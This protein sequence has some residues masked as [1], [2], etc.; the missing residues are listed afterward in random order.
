MTQHREPEVNVGEVMHQIKADIA[1]QNG[2]AFRQSGK[3]SPFDWSRLMMNMTVA[4]QHA[5][6]GSRVL[7]MIRF[8]PAIRWLVRL[9]GRVV[10]YLAQVVTIPQ[11]MYNQAVL[12]VLRD[13][14]DGVR[15]LD[16]SISHLQTSLTLQER[17]F[18]M[19][20][21]E[22]EQKLPRSTRPGANTGENPLDEAKAH[23]LD[24]FY[25]SFEDRFRG[26]RDEIKQH[27]QFYLPFFKAAPPGQDRA[28]ILDL[29]CGRGE[30]LELL[31]D[32]NLNAK[33]IDLN[34]IMVDQ[35]REQG[36]AV[37]EADALAYLR[38]IEEDSLGA[39]TAFHL[40]EHLELGALVNIIN[41]I[42]RVLRPGG[43]VLFETPNPENVAV[44]ACNFYADPTH[45]N[46]IYPPTIQ[47]IIEQRGFCKVK[48]LYP[49]KDDKPSPYQYID[50]NHPLAESI[51]PLVGIARTH[52]S[53]SA[54][55]AVIGWKVQ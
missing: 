47:F 41:E 52:F 44:G 2:E 32:T 29:G 15:K 42:M 33:G 14:M 30:W 12:Q 34:Q 54:D 22:T 7:P 16:Q 19:L 43:L 39:V 27:L 21:D 45:R 5:D 3:E 31:R 36:L 11:R 48:L 40:I 4:E 8:H 25:V 55:F 51:N 38:R 24:P 46:P 18:K 10:V 37:T 23:L 20:L 26:S 1:Q 28:M 9:V 53:A 50:E 13:S 6:A 17:R 49:Q 35:C